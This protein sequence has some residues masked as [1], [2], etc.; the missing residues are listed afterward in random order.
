MPILIAL[1]VAVL[2]L[3][4]LM[5]VLLPFGL[6]Q[7][8][9]YGSSRRRAYPRL[10]RLNAWLLV[11]STLMFAV[12][13]WI[14]GHWVPHAP[15]FAVAGL[16]L[17]ALLGIVGAWTTR[18]EHVDGRS[19]YTPN[20]WLVLSLT[21]LVVVRIALGVWQAWRTPPVGDPGLLATLLA[22]HGNLFGIGGVLLGYALAYA[23][24]ISAR[25]PRPSPG[26]SR[27]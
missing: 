25:T 27:A 15:M 11:V 8:Y 24:C 13:A 9:R 7:R 22:D 1:P 26:T 5:L 19:H 17:G 18:F 23:W 3:V 21:L 6:V 20:R 10:L 12:A 14:T 4:M 2:L 16:L